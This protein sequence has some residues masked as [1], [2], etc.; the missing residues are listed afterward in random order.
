MRPLRAALPIVLGSVGFVRPAAATVARFR[1]AVIDRAERAARLL[2]Q[3]LFASA[4]RTLDA[5]FGGTPPA[6]V[7]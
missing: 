2:M 7:P 4:D 1:M 6:R 3:N 5:V